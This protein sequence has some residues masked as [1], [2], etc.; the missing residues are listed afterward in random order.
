MNSQ[1]I[2]AAAVSSGKTMLTNNTI[3]WLSLY[4]PQPPFTAMDIIFAANRATDTKRGRAITIRVLD[5]LENG[6]LRRPGSLTKAIFADKMRVCDWC[7]GAGH[8]PNKHT[9]VGSGMKKRTPCSHCQ[10]KGEFPEFSYTD[11]LNF[12]SACNATWQAIGADCE[13]LEGMDGKKHRMTKA[14]VVEVTLDADYMDMYGT[15][16]DTPFSQEARDKNPLIVRNR[17]IRYSN[18]AKKWCRE[19]IF[20][21]GF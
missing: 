7:K 4:R 14:E 1:D 11:K 13:N 8:F 19:A 15:G 17:Q 6:T 21:R 16:Y 18:V 3:R 20:G 5:Y 9:M 10:G 2:Y 12:M